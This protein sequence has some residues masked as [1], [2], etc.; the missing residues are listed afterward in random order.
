[1]LKVLLDN[2]SQLTYHKVRMAQRKSAFGMKTF[3]PYLS[4]ESKLNNTTNE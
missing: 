4:F 3:V 1:M 2:S